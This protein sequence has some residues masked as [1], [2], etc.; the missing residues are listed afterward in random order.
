[1]G[2]LGEKFNSITQHRRELKL[3]PFACVMQVLLP[4]ARAH[5]RHLKGKTVIASDG[6]P[7]AK[8]HAVTGHFLFLAALFVTRANGKEI[9]RNLKRERE[10]RKRSCCLN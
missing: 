8:G 10:K 6:G 5:G 1:M 2:P 9:K 4:V 3:M 7:A